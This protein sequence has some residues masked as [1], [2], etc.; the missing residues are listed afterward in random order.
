[1]LDSY[2]NMIPQGAFLQ[3]STMPH[4]AGNDPPNVSNTS[5]ME[6]KISNMR[7]KFL[8]SMTKLVESRSYKSKVFSKEKYF[9]TIKAVK[10]AEEKGKK[11]SR[12]YRHAAKYDMISVGGTEKLI[13]AP[14]G[15]RHRIRYYV[16]KAEL[17]DI[18]HDTH[19]NIGHGGRTHMLKELQAKY[20]NITKEVIVLYLTV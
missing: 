10:E 13:E 3:F 4:R 5:E 9:Q 2:E 20:G 11:S 19:L 17:F 6:M 15:E 1:M 7:E 18:L 12:D 14:H 8:I 16:H